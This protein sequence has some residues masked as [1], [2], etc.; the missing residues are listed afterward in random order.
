MEYWL[1]C[2]K[3]YAVFSGRA[4][5]KE[6]WMFALFNVLISLAIGIVLAIVGAVQAASV[7]QGLYQ[8]AI[9][10]PGLAVCARRLHDI[11]KSGWW[12]LI[13]LI[14]LVGFIVLLVFLCTDSQPDEN[15]YGPNP[16]N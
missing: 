9:L 10:I 13:A 3:K 2:W 7:I 5:R 8:L 1:N 16:K 6:Y 12:M 11:G 15:D 4:R 14:P